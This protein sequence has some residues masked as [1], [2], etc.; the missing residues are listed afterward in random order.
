S[1]PGLPL[2]SGSAHGHLDEL[3]NTADAW[4]VTMVR[5]RTYRFGVLTRSG[6]CVDVS[7]FA[8]GTQSFN[9]EPVATAECGELTLFT[10]GPDGGGVYSALVR[11]DD[12][13]T[14]YHLLVKAAQPDDM[15]PG[16]LLASGKHVQGAVS[17]A[18]PLDLYR[19]DVPGTSNVQVR[20]TTEA[21]G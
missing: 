17:A 14:N 5:G 7:L 12:A 18:D 8:P 9:A 4:A 3:Q 21:D 13:P 16:A 10:P 11:L 2:A 6:A 1:P 20:V 19:F 15:A